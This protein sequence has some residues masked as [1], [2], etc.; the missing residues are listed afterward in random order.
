MTHICVSN[1]HWFR[2]WL[3]AWSAPSHYLNQ[4]WNI[5]NSNL[6][7]KLQWNLKQHTF[8]FKKIHLKMSSAKFWPFCLGLNV[9]KGVPD[10][11]FKYWLGHTIAAVVAHTKFCNSSVI[12]YW[13]KAA[14]GSKLHMPQIGIILS[15]IAH[16]GQVTYRWLSA[17]LQ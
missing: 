15:C 14:F 17:I 16:W 4:C 10:H 6:R 1:H 5:V 7:N 3:V 11:Y 8:S 2:Q 13:I 9:L 12:R